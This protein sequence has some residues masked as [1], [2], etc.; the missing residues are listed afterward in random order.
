[1]MQVSKVKSDTLTL[2]QQESDLGQT[3]VVAARDAYWRQKIDEMEDEQAK[4]LAAKVRLWR[5]LSCLFLSACVVLL[6]SIPEVKDS[7]HN[8]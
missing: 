6:Y 5:H 7:S 1:M 4:H 2:M 8:I 3:K